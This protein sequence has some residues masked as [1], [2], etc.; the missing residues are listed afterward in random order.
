VKKEPLI[1]CK[2]VLLTS[3]LVLASCAG[4]GRAASREG[5]VPGSHIGKDDVVI[6][7]RD[8]NSVSVSPRSRSLVLQHQW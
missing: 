6:Y 8:S 5:E 4:G 2:C 1:A 3:I 7:Q